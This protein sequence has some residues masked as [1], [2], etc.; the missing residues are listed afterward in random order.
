M[1]QPPP[2]TIEIA[3]TDLR[4]GMSVRRSA[5]VGGHT[6]SPIRSI[7]PPRQLND[8]SWIVAIGYGHGEGAAFDSD[9]R[10]TVLA[11]Q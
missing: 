1:T 9:D 10:V 8:G 5:W 7:Q 11:P 6:Y 2:A 3:A 4:V